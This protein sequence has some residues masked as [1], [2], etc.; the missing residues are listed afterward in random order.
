MNLCAGFHNHFLETDAFVKVAHQKNK[1]LDS[2]QAPIDPMISYSIKIR[3]SLTEDG[4]LKPELN[5]IEKTTQV[6]IMSLVYW[7]CLKNNF[8]LHKPT[9]TADFLSQHD[10]SFDDFAVHASRKSYEHG[11]RRRKK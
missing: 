11:I 8:L 4:C 3:N 7:F 6:K 2:I 5:Y 9:C 10:Q 1:M